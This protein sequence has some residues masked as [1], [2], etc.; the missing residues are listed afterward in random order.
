MLIMKL[1]YLILALVLVCVL[2][3]WYSTTGKDFY[4]NP[5]SGQAP[6]TVTIGAMVGGLTPGFAYRISFGDGSPEASISC[7]APEDVCVEAG[8]VTHTYMTPGTYL[9]E[10]KTY[11]IG[12]RTEDGEFIVVDGIIDN[13]LKVTVR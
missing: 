7:S 13:T 12:G 8:E 1:I 9:V 2:S 3:F 6:L 4:A 10:L 5:I 11:K